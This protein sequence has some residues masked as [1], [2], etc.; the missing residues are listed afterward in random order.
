[1][2]YILEGF[3]KDIEKAKTTDY[4]QMTI[5]HI[6]P[7]KEI[8]NGIADEIIGQLG[9]MILIPAELNDELKDKSF[10]KKKAILAN[11]NVPL[12][13]TL[14]NA[15][16]WDENSIKQRTLEMAEQAYTRLWRI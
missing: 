4:S 6:L 13:E 2:R 16:K 14:Q 10:R 9:N 7:Q 11:A 3:H 15:T 1:V 8:K 12:S 5:E